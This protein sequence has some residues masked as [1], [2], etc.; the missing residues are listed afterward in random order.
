[1]GRVGLPPPREDGASSRQIERVSV[2]LPFPFQHTLDGANLDQSCRQRHCSSLVSRAFF[3][4]RFWTHRV[5]SEIVCQPLQLDTG[6]PL[7]D[8]RISV[9][10]FSALSSRS[11]IESIVSRASFRIAY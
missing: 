3:F 11:N 4:V 8:E 10:L 6:A 5:T 2:S 9:V 7:R 1:M